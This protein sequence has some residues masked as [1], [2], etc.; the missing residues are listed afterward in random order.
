MPKLRF[1]R[2]FLFLSILLFSLFICSASADPWVVNATGDAGIT[3]VGGA[4]FPESFYNNDRWELIVTATEGATIPTKGGFY[5]LDST[6]VSDP[7]IINGLPDIGVWLK[8]SVFNDGT[9]KLIS[10]EYW[11]DFRG[12]YWNGTSW[13]EDSS[14]VTGLPTLSEQRPSPEIFYH[15]D[16]WKMIVGLYSGGFTSYYWD[17]SGNTWIYDGS[18]SAGLGDVGDDATPAV[19]EEFGILYLI[20][21]DREALWHGYYWSGT[22]WISDSSVISGLHDISGYGS[23]TIFSQSGTWRMITGNGVGHYT[24]FEKPFTN[25]VPVTSELKTEGEV[26]NLQI[27][28]GT[29]NPTF[30]W[31]YYDMNDDVQDSYE[32]RVGTSLGISDMWTSGTLLGSATSKAYGGLEL[33]DN[34]AYYVQVRTNDGYEWSAWETG[35]FVVGISGTSPVVIPVSA[36]ATIS[37]A[38][39]TPSE[40]IPEPTP[41]KTIVEEVVSFITE[42]FNW[43]LIVFAYLGAFLGRSLLTSPD[44]DLKDLAIDTALFGTVAFVLVLII[45]SFIPLVAMG[46][47]VAVFSFAAAGFVLSLLRSLD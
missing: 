3:Y 41:S 9:L 26:N 7:T 29:T 16:T 1:T 42:P 4:A 39:S 14:I 17:D 47:F 32:I 43:I 22:S 8:T 25:I 18:I 20:S 28:S 36:P 35:V 31:T 11:G 46:E 24:A 34:V 23:S 44:E 38:P 45:N 10:G 6:W 37:A 5:W 21:G 19:F 15:D 33:T 40:P 27:P 30:S 2:K 12:F 13:V